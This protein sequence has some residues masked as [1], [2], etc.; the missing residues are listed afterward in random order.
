MRSMAVTHRYGL[1]IAVKTDEQ[2]SPVSFEWRHATYVVEEIIGTWH[3]RDRWWVSRAAADLGLEKYPSDRY[4]FRVQLPGSAFFEI[5][6][7]AAVNDW[8]LDRILD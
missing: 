4:Y 2:G 5:Y 8:I 3:V 6:Y 7:D 1:P